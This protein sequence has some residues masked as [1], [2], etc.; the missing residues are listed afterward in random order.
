VQRALLLLLLLLLL[1]PVYGLVL[2]L[3]PDL[4]RL[5]VLLQWKLLLPLVAAAA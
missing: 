4:P 5:V 1:L 3:A 2:V